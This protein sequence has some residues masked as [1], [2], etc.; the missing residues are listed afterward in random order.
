ML[1]HD[2]LK[3]DSKIILFDGAMGTEIFKRGIEPGK[4]PDVL[5]IEKPD[6]ISDI[7]KSY[8]D[9]G[10]DMCQTCTFG[11]SSLNLKKYKL[12][13][14]IEEINQKALENIKKICPPNCVIVGDIGPSGEFRPPVGNITIEQW[15]A[16]FANQVKILENGVDLWHI[17]TISD[18]EEMKIA[19]KAV[20]AVSKKPIIASMTYKKT[21]RGYFTIMGDSLEK[22]IQIL[23]QENVDVIG[24]NCTISSNDMIGLIKESTILTNKP[25]SAKPN[26]GMPKLDDKG[27]AFYDYPVKD[28]AKDIRKIIDLGA[29]IVGGCCGTSPET[30]KEI[31]KII[32]SL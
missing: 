23:E 8:Y 1:F 6:I 29:K 13:D 25:L 2:W 9:V 20:K 3:N 12:E 31:R 7:H 32:D 19:I 17:E 26:A 14:R 15:Q 27:R 4:I 21:P 16:S 11:S 18:I 5:N 24:S 10:S 28:F 30:I 22:C